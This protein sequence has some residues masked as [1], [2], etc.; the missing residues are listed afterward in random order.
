MKDKKCFVFRL[1]GDEFIIILNE[2]DHINEANLL[3]ENIL[4]M[5]NKPMSIK[6]NA[7]YITSS[8]GIS[9][10]PTDGIKGETLVEKQILP[11]IYGN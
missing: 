6:N 9:N 7:I 2:I 3:A 10:F 8:I 11:S 1:S 5:I 4:Q